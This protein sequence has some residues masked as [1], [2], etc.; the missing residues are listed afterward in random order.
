MA[1]LWRYNED[2]DIWV[3]VS[4]DAPLPD[5][6]DTNLPLKLGYKSDKP[7]EAILR[8]SATNADGSVEVN[9]SLIENRIN[10]GS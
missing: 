1:K 10:H 7:M 4:E 6:A 5:Q 3:K 9:T 8:I 2:S